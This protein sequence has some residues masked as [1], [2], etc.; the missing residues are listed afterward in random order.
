MSDKKTDKI[1]DEHEVDFNTEV[2]LLVADFETMKSVSDHMKLN[3]NDDGI[4]KLLEVLAIRQRNRMLQQKLK[5]KPLFPPAIENILMK[6]GANLISDLT[7]EFTKEPV[8]PGDGSNN[9]FD[10]INEHLKGV[11]GSWDIT[12]NALVFVDDKDRPVLFVPIKHLGKIETIE[13]IMKMPFFKLDEFLPVY[14]LACKQGGIKPID[15]TPN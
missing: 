13:G 8:S 1:Y 12:D 10:D 7:N 6:A 9:V 11:T 2:S 14:K 3:L 4:I 5:P 15:L